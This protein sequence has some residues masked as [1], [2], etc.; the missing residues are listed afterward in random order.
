MKARTHLLFLCLWIVGCA[1]L[2]RSCSSCWAGAVGADWLV[3][4]VKS[5][6][7]VPYR[8]WELTD[9]SVVNEQQSDGVYWKDRITGNLVHIAGQYNRVQVVGGNWDHAYSQVGITKE[10]CKKIQATLYSGASPASQP[11]EK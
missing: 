4:Q 3:V 9:V 7:G 2:G 8:C 1:G 10:G 5:F 11:A 6:D